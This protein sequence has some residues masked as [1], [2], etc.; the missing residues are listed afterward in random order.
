MSDKRFTEIVSTQRI[1]DNVTGK[2]YN[3]LV[4]N[5]LFI[6]I[7]DIIEKN[8]EEIERMKS[9]LN[10][11]ALELV[12]DVISMGKAVEISEMSYHD[13]IHYRAKNG[14]PMELQL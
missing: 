13:F 1:R 11:T 10:E 2:E 8:E 3:G 14:K 12:G 9:K 4:D 5:E 7:N 6:L